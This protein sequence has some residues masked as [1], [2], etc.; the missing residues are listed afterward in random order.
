MYKRQK[1][2]GAYAASY[3]DWGGNMKL[4][5]KFNARTDVIGTGAE[6]EA[7]NAA[8]AARTDWDLAVCRYNIR[9]NS[10]TSS[11]TGANGGVYTISE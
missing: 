2:D 7:D 1:G 11:S 4:G 5:Y 3:A 10:G 6:S 9:T 8:W